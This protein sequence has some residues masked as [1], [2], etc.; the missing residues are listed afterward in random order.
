MPKVVIKRWKPGLQK[1]SLTKLLQD[2]A[3]FSLASA[4][5]CVDRVLDGETVSI[6]QANLEEAI[7]LAREI[8]KLGAVCE[9]KE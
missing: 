1:V 2:R 7:T 5:E 4:K 8:T 6:A 9:V 3:G